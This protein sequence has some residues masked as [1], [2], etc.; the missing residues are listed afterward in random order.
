MQIQKAQSPH[1]VIINHTSVDNLS[2]LSIC[3]CDSSAKKFLFRAVDMRESSAVSMLSRSN[4][5]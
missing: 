1:T 5:R 3:C 4:I 2:Q